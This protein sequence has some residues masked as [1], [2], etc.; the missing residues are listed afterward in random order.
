MNHE[1]Q[2]TSLEAL[3]KLKEG[4]QTYLKALTNPG[5]IS[6]A[7]RV[8]TKEQGQFPYAIIITCS[9]S[10]VIPEAI[11]SAGIG[12]LFV[13]RL[14]G[15]VIDAH[16]LGSIEYAAEHLGSP[17]IV[18]MGHTHCGA[19][20]AA[21]HHDAEG[22]IKFITD[23]ICLAIGD[24]TDPHEACIKN[25]NHSLSLIQHSLEIQHVEETHDLAAVGAVY[26]I[27]TGAVEFLPLLRAGEYL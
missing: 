3:N 5:D 24:E 15:N 21:M 20:D 6:P 1:W 23:E 11:F 25:V 26:D 19:V 8:T 17:L 14:A 9:D 13:I 2:M 27:E 22:F 7:I 12:E 18:V 10:R 16:Q 4:N